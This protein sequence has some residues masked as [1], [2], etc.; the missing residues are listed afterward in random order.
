VEEPAIAISCKLTE[1]EKV[2]LSKYPEVKDYSV[3]LQ[4]HQWGGN[5]F[6]FKKESENVAVTGD[7]DVDIENYPFL[8]GLKEPEEE[9]SKVVRCV[10]GELIWLK[11]NEW[12]A[13]SG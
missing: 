11:D 13:I 8:I 6:A 7:K 4:P 12:K 1:A 2:L 10:V 9:G 3:V 5:H